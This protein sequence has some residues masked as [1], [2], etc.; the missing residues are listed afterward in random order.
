MERR[1]EDKVDAGDHALSVQINDV[2][3]NLNTRITQVE[4]KVDRQWMK[5]TWA[6]SIVGTVG[7]GLVWLVNNFHLFLAA[8]RATGAQ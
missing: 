8:S 1:I 3:T 6:V 2:S 5:I 4:A 7:A